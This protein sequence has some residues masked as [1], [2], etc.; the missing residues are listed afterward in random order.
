ML[1]SPKLILSDWSPVL[2]PLFF[3]AA[4]HDNSVLQRRD[5]KYLS[6][7]Y[8]L[9]FHSSMT[10]Y[11]AIDT[12]EDGQRKHVHSKNEIRSPSLMG[13]NR[14]QGEVGTGDTPGG[15]S[16]KRE[17]GRRATKHKKAKRSNKNK[18][19]KNNVAIEVLLHPRWQKNLLLLLKGIKLEERSASIA[20]V[21]LLHLVYH[22][23]LLPRSL[24]RQEVET[25]R[26]VA[27]S[28]LHRRKISPD[29]KRLG[30]G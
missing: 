25:G 27:D 14:D 4:C 16:G 9:I 18:H 28:K 17:R 26:W 22:R 8:T 13:S 2:H 3:L 12:T 1:N 7:W 20:S 5:W 21:H 6:Y 29:P 19:L 23:H 30:H 15:V 11:N 10:D 24:Q